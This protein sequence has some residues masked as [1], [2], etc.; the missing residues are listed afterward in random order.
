MNTKRNFSKKVFSMLIVFILILSMLPIQSFAKTAFDPKEDHKQLDLRFWEDEQPDIGFYINASTRYILETV[1]EPKMG[2]TFGEWSVMDLLRG[3][4]TGYDYINYIPEDYFKNYLKGIEGYVIGKEGNLDRNKSTEWSRLI[5]T[6]SSLGYDITNVGAAGEYFKTYWTENTGI[7][8]AIPISGNEVV[9]SN[10]AKIYVNALNEKTNRYT[11]Q[12]VEF[13]AGKYSLDKEANTMTDESGNIFKRAK[14][15]V[16][17]LVPL[18]I[19]AFRRANDLAMAMEA[20][21]YRGGDG[22]TKMKPLIYKKRDFIAY[23]VIL[24]YLVSKVLVG[25]YL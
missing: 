24:V 21:C 15:L 10:S 5:L 6:L 8:N 17:I 9:L 13:P 20:R 11:N 19:S 14:A 4:Y 2:S 1:T 16:P 22:R 3:M 25:I 18:F 23:L 7:I 12:Y